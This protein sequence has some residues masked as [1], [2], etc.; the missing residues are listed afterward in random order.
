MSIAASTASTAALTAGSCSIGP[1]RIEIHDISIVSGDTGATATATRLHQVD[2]AMLI[3][4]VTQTA[5][6][7][8]SGKVATLTFTNPATT[9]KG[10]VL[11]F[12]K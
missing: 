8:Y 9:V 10:H 3:A 1:T 2:Y 6:S 11:L 12:G 4:D 5:V 7:T